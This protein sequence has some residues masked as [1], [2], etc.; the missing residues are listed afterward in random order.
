MKKIEMSAR[1]KLSGKTLIGF[2][3]GAG[4]VRKPAIKAL[5][6]ELKRPD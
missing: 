5:Q 4:P 2:E 1:E 3:R 6:I